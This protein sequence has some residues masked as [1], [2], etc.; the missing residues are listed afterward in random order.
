M[1]PQPIW[2]RIDSND[3]HKKVEFFAKHWTVLGSIS[4]QD[5]A[6]QNFASIIPYGVKIRVLLQDASRQK[7]SILIVLLI[8]DLETASVDY[9]V[10][11]GLH[12]GTWERHCSTRSR[13]SF[14]FSASFSRR[15]FIASADVLS[16]FLPCFEAGSELLIVSSFYGFGAFEIYHVAHF[17]CWW[18]TFG[19]TKL[20][21]QIQHF[22]SLSLFHDVVGIRQCEQRI[23][24]I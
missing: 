12:S 8:F 15:A 1:V 21:N 17:V 20:L 14:I 22:L 3:L 6:E 11:P 10:S 19:V 13:Y 4:F 23:T 5:T 16:R 9:T 2:F 18:W 7:Q 24:K